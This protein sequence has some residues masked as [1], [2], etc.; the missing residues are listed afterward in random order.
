MLGKNVRMH[1]GIDIGA[2]AGQTIKASEADTVINA[3]WIT[4]YGKTVIIDHGNGY[5]TLYA[6]GSALLTGVGQEVQQGQ[7]IAK[8]GSTGWA[9][10]PNL[11]FEVRKGGQP[12]EPLQYLS[13]R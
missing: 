7:P 1:N 10:G 3:G 11:H 5:S 9:T 8:V 4:G 12:Q 6:H 2:P 13:D